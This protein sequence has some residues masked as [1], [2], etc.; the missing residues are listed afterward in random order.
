MTKRQFGIILIAFI[1]MT[2]I[3]GCGGDENADTVDTKNLKAESFLPE[4]VESLNLTRTSEVKTYVGESLYEYI[5]GGAEVYHLY[6]FEE[7]AT[8]YYKLGE[9]ATEYYELGEVEIIADVYQFATPEGSFG[10]FTTLRDPELEIVSYGSAGFKTGSSIDF[11]KGRYLI[12]LTGFNESEATQ[13]FI[14]SFAAYFAEV[15]PGTSEL[16]SK[17]N[18]FPLGEVV[19]ASEIIHAEAYLGRGYLNDVYLESMIVEGDTLTLFLIPNEGQ[20]QKWYDEMTAE[21]SASSLD[22]PLGYDEGT[23]F[24]IESSFYG[25]I[26]AGG[27]GSWLAGV[28]GYKPS[29]ASF[30][31]AWISSLK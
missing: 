17:F 3:F 31:T 2:L 9:V 24:Q 18:L 7:V 10:M 15:V 19:A 16:P 13:A 30:V 5:N 25:T 29:H 27:N 22:T 14:N 1:T 26:V 6:Q 20:Y 21:G 8:A 12:R 4:S 11:V 28:S 23:G